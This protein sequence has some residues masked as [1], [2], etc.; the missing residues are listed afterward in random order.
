MLRCRAFA[1]VFKQPGSVCKDQGSVTST[2]L[3]RPRCETYLQQGCRIL[4]AAT[5]STTAHYQPN[6]NK[7]WYV[8]YWKLYLPWLHTD[9]SIESNYGNEQQETM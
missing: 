3:H 4:W 1:E 8:A 6:R 5:T 9:Q 2:L 7:T